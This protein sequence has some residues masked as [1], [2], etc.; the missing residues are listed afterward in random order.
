MDGSGIN[1]PED[2]F[3][4]DPEKLARHRKERQE[5][6]FSAADWW[7]FDTYIAGVI[8][9]ALIKFRDEGHGYPHGSSEEEFKTLCTE[10]A[11]PLL[12]YA[13]NKFKVFGDKEDKMYNDAVAAMIKFSE[14][15]GQWWD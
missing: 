10:I 11:E 8:G 1:W 15:L 13:E 5:H 4:N 2:S 14:N 7:S 6:G 12:D 9:R 3:R